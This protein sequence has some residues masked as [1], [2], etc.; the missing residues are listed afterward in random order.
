MFLRG[1][2]QKTAVML[3]CHGSEGFSEPL[4]EFSLFTGLDCKQ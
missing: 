4:G 1:K 2:K 3:K